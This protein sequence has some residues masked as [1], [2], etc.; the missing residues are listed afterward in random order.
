MVPKLTVSSTAIDNSTTTKLSLSPISTV[1][2]G[3]FWP[4][5]GLLSSFFNQT[6]YRNKRL[7]LADLDSNQRL[8]NIGGVSAE[9]SRYTPLPG[10]HFSAIII[11]AHLAPRK[12]NP[13][14]LQAGDLT[15]L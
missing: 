9:D 10:S 2:G 8:Q 13:G 4:I 6:N 1:S 12:F 14:S 11:G 5:A 7:P 3:R 15:D